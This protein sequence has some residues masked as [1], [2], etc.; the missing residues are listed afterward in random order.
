MV[1][2]IFFVSVKIQLYSNS[3]FYGSVYYLSQ[4][5][6][7]KQRH[8]FFHVIPIL[9]VFTVF[10]DYFITF[11]YLLFSMSGFLEAVSKVSKFA[12]R[13]DDDFYD[14]LSHRYTV[15]FLALFTVVREKTEVV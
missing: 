3:G 13:W 10:F 6:T 12:L 11:Y 7:Q 15:M 14:R 9:P 4:N 5:A 8:Y 2:S 1:R